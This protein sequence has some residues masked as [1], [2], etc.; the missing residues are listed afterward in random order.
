[1]AKKSCFRRHGMVW[2][3]ILEIEMENVTEAG[4]MFCGDCCFEELGVFTMEELKQAIDKIDGLESLDEIDIFEGTA[5]DIAHDE[6]KRLAKETHLY[7][8]TAKTGLAVPVSVLIDRERD[9]IPSRIESAAESVRKF[10]LSAGFAAESAKTFIAAW[11]DGKWV[12]TGGRSSRR[13][14]GVGRKRW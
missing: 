5:L 4:K 7:Q 8:T 11:R 3:S 9:R 13:K 1:M 10:S 2:S 12:P 6:I 14:M